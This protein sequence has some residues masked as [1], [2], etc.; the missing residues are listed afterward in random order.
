[1]SRRAWR[2][3]STATPMSPTR[4]AATVTIVN[5][6]GSHARHA[7][8]RCRAVEHRRLTQRP[9]CLR[10]QQRPGH[11]HV[12]RH[13]IRARSSAAWIFATAH[14]TIPDRNRHFQPR[15]MAV[16]LD[17]TKLYVTR[18]LSFT[19]PG[20]LAGHR[21]WQRGRGLP[22]IESAGALSTTVPTRVHADQA[23]VAGHRLHGPDRRHR[24]LR[25]L[26]L[27]EPA[28]KHRAFVATRPI[29]RISRHR[30]PARSGSMSTRRR[31]SM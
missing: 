24:R 30:R 12:I 10:G 13:A 16:T 25:H 6:S 20:G 21:Q 8:N 29:C 5:T 2:L 19:K 7:D 31:S 9:A 15:G 4:P 26:G 17:N 22:V 28:A 11:D 23:G 14:A 27:P 18:F 3:T 1:M